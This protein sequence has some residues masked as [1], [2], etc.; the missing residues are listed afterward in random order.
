MDKV[1]M[2]MAMV[3]SIHEKNI[4]FY[5]F[6]AKIRQDGGFAKDFRVFFTIYYG[7]ALFSEKK[8]LSLLRIYKKLTTMKHFVK[9]LILALAVCGLASCENEIFESNRSLLVGSW[10]LMEI[11]DI[12]YTDGVAGEPVDYHHGDSALFTYTFNKDKTWQFTYNFG[13]V[14]PQTGTY[15]V[16]GKQII[17]IGSD[18]DEKD[19]MVIESIDKTFMELSSISTFDISMGD[20]IVRWNPQTSR[21]LDGVNNYVKIVMHF[22]RR[23]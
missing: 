14:A 18:G 11:T 13:K 20:E 16:E 6:A 15:K 17:C 8:R 19:N 3:Q 9:T 2:V 7:N 23:K 12:R 1:M 5:L 22:K 21:Q 10:N 4:L